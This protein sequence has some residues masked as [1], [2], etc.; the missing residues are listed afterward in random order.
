[1]RVTILRK[2]SA[3]ATLFA[4]GCA[5]GTP[6]DDVEI[7]GNSKVV[8]A[9]GQDDTPQ[10][11]D[12]PSMRAKDGGPELGAVAFLVSIYEKPDRRSNKL[13]YLRVGTRVTRAEKPA[14]F[15]ACRG[16]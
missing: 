2:A 3:L 7:I 9:D 6:V 15:D 11:A 14:A 1:M 4:L 5:E 10:V 16:G 12:D 8:P 13:G